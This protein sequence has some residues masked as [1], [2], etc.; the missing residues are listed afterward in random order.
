MIIDK[1][2]RS[3]FVIDQHVHVGLRPA[4]S[5]TASASYLPDELITNMDANGVDM[6]V[7]FPSTFEPDCGFCADQ[8]VLWRESG[9]RYT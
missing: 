3:H 1:A 2:G 5:T 6:V 8:P 7:G 9:C 4:R